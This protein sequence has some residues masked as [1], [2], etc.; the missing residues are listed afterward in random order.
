MGETRINL[1]SDTQTRPTPEM[2]PDLSD[3]FF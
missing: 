3:E 1:Y 2:T